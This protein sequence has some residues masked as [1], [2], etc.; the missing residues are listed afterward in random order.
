MSNWEKHKAR[1][2]KT[3]KANIN[4]QRIGRRNAAPV[5][6][7]IA[8]AIAN[9]PAAVSVDASQPQ[10]CLRDRKLRRGPANIGLAQFLVL[11]RSRALG[12]DGSCGPVGGLLKTSPPHSPVLVRA[13]RSSVMC[14]SWRAPVFLGIS[15]RGSFCFCLV[16]SRVPQR[17]TSVE[18]LVFM[19]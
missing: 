11:V 19:E 4:K 18:E 14:T 5:S 9:R 10:S 15:D 3:K 1:Q 7:A 16:V 6:D 12:S 8:A 17:A 2:N 13:G